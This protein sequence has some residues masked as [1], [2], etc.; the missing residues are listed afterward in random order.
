MGVA[1]DGEKKTTRS[2]D[3]KDEVCPHVIFL[4]A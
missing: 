1:L 4:I 3:Q 2:E